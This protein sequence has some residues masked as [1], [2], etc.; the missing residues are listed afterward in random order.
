MMPEK[1]S[2]PVLPSPAPPEDVDD[3]IFR[4]EHDSLTVSER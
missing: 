2:S 3:Y 4:W 1:D